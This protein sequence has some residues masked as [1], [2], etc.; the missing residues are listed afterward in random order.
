MTERII[1]YQKAVNEAVAQEMRRDPDVVILGEDIAGGAGRE[2]QGIKDVWGGAFGTTKGLVSEFGSQRV[3]DTPITESGFMG[4]AIGSAATGLRPIVELMFV[5]FSGVAFDQI[6]NQAAKLRY[7]FGGKAKIPLTICCSIGGGMNAAAQ[8]SQ[9][10]YSLFAHIPGLKGI[11][12]ATPYDMKGLLASAIRD[13]DPVMVFQHKGLLGMK[14]NVPEESYTIPL[15]QADIKRQGQD[16]TLVA[17]SRMVHVCLEAAQTLEA[18][19]ISAEVLDL[20]SLSPLDERAVL[21]SVAKTGRLVVVDEDTPR[22]SMAT[23]IAALAA[24]QGF[25]HL[26]APIKR[27]TAPHTPVPFSPPLEKFYLPDAQKVIAAVKE[28]LG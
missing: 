2:D 20:R 23:D 15:G 25:D 8:H 14:E 7:M 12:P 9:V 28:L 22:C 6:M 13:D 26:D 4:A 21:E 27:V 24:D 18:D 1:S 19:G 11:A 3:L 10:L 17:I 5:D 16:V